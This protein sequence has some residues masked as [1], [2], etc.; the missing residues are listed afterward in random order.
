MSS[1]NKMLVEKIIKCRL[2]RKISNEQGL[3][4]VQ[5]FD[6]CLV[7]ALMEVALAEEEELTIRSFAPKDLGIYGGKVFIIQAFP[8]LD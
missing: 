6:L 5:N 2:I 1:R 3:V 7:N 8:C 4:Q